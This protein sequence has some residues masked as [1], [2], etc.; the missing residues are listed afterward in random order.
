M[1][2]SDFLGY[3]AAILGGF[4][5]GSIPVI[6]G[7]LRNLG[8]SSLVQSVLRLFFGAIIGLS[9]LLYFIIRKQEEIKLCFSLKPQI[10]FIIHGG[11]LAIIIV[12]YLTSI[13][14]HT[15]AG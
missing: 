4:S 5:F 10:S 15:P 9:V 13:A 7:V 14:L 11:I 1:K 12:L 3:V 2:R 8:S 6:S